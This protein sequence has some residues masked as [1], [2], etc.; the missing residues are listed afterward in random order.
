MQTPKY[1]ITHTLK[2]GIEVIDL[3]NN[4]VIKPGDKIVYLP[5]FKEKGQIL[6]KYRDIPEFQLKYPQIDKWLTIGKCGIVNTPLESLKSG[7]MTDFGICLTDNYQPEILTPIFLSDDTC[8]EYHICVV[9]LMEDEYTIEQPS[10]NVPT[11]A[12]SYTDLDSYVVYDLVTRYCLD[13]F[14]KT[15]SLF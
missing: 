11:V 2:E 4:Q 10:S 8:A 5:Y 15:Y 6:L 1:T 9:S 12:L 14:R 13:L 3:W 7:L